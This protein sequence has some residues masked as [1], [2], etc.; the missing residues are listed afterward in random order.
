MRLLFSK[1]KASPLQS[2]AVTA[3]SLNKKRT[4]ETS[5]DI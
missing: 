2:M 4:E 3:L 5:D 1:G